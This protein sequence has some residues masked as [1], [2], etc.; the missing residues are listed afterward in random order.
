MSTF[1]ENDCNSFR[2]SLQSFS[3]VGSMELIDSFPSPIGCKSSPLN[4]KDCKSLFK[5]PKEQTSIIYAS[6]FPRVL[7]IIQEL[8]ETL[9]P[10]NIKDDYSFQPKAVFLR[11]PVK[12]K[13]LV[14]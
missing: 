12:R 6:V 5:V 1:D 10:V 14:S 11:V 8:H 4:P 9:P 2:A 13:T 3:T 7:D